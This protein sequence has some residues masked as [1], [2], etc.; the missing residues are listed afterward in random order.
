ML[1]ENCTHTS[2]REREKEVEIENKEVV[3]YTIHSATTRTEF[4]LNDIMDFLTSSHR[5]PYGTTL[6]P[7]NALTKIAKG[8]YLILL[9]F[10]QHFCAHG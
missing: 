1:D 3:Y 2:V 4:R 8:K 10:F 5:P 7:A 9:I 6:N